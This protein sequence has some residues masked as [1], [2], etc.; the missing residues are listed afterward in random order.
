[1]YLLQ[2]FHVIWNCL[3]KLKKMN[4]WVPHELNENHKLQ[5]F[6][7]SS[8]FLRNQNDPFLNQIVTSDEKWILKDK[9]KCLVQYLDANKAPQ[10]FPKLKLHQKKVMVTVWR[11]LAG[12]THHSF[13][14]LGETITAKKHCRE[15][16]EIHQKLTCN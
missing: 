13:I 15:I 11:S 9:L 3:A 7:I 8:A 10:N 6:E 16:N 12:L 4:K 14:K 5:S 2:P 1:M